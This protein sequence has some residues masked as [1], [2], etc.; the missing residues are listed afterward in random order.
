MN[1]LVKIFPCLPINGKRIHIVG[2]LSGGMLSVRS[3]LRSV[4]VV[5]L[6][7]SARAVNTLESLSFTFPVHGK[8][9]G[10]NFLTEFSFN[11]YVLDFLS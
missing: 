9:Q 3:A 10:Q 11:L 6:L 1:F 4:R 8:R 2:S 7:I 5:L